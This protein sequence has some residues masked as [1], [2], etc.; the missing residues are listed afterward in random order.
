MAISPPLSPLFS[1]LPVPKKMAHISCKVWPVY[2]QFLSGKSR[3]LRLTYT[4]HTHTPAQQ[5][6]FFFFFLV[7]R[8][9]GR[10]RSLAEGMQE[11]GAGLDDYKDV[12]ERIDRV[13]EKLASPRKCPVPDSPC[14]HTPI[15]LSSRQEQRLK[16]TYASLVQQQQLNVLHQTVWYYNSGNVARAVELVQ[17]D[18]L[19]LELLRHNDYRLPL[20][21]F[22]CSFVFKEGRVVT[23]ELH[24]QR[25]QQQQSAMFH[26]L[27]QTRIQPPPRD[28]LLAQQSAIF[29]ELLQTRIIPKI[30]QK[31]LDKQTLTA[32]TTTTRCRIWKVDARGHKTLAI[33]MKQLDNTF[34]FKDCGERTSFAGSQYVNPDN[35]CEARVPLNKLVPFLSPAD[36]LLAGFTIPLAFPPAVHMLYGTRCVFDTEESGHLVFYF[37]CAIR[38]ECLCLRDK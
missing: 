33:N 20:E 11:E 34:F 32:L 31:P 4:E 2:M 35:P 3:S 22:S 14:P 8:R 27:R 25:N 38:D 13:Q 37:P 10:A 6:I 19:E 36:K 26:E 17:K 30:P 18:L 16:D 12:Q 1:S 23:Q 28:N 7:G 15:C 9:S 24:H 21:K 5:N 29:H